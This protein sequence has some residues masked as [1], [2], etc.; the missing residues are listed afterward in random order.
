MK[1]SPSLYYLVSIVFLCLT[2]TACKKTDTVVE[3]YTAIAAEFNTRIDPNNLANYA[4]QGKPAYINKD[5]A[6]GTVITDA[7]ATLGRVL[8]YD[9]QLSVNNTT[10]CGSCHVQKFAFSDTAL[11]SLGVQG[12]RT[13]RHSM[14][15]INT[16][17]SNERRFFWDERAATLE[18]Q[19]TQPI[20]DHAEMGFSGQDGRPTFASLL[21]KLQAIGY[22]QELF[23][24][25]YGDE[26]VTEQRL[27]ECLS[28][29]VR[30]IQSFD[31]K[32]DQG[33]AIAP[34]NQPFPNFTQ[35]ENT[36]K[37]LFQAPP[38]F[39][40]DGVRIAGGLGCAGC[41]A[42]PEFSIDPNSGNNGII[43]VLNGTG[44]DINNTRAPSLRDLVG[45]DGLPN[46]PMMH[47]GGITS[48]NTLIGHYGRIN[49]APGNTRLDPRL[50]PNGLGQNLVLNANEVDAV[51]AFLKT[52]T[53]NAVYTDA[54]WSDPFV[55]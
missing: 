9:K 19:S 1:A 15:L 43:G 25:V 32:Y 45:R 38:Q 37:N 35:Q 22:Y 50:R 5:N 11:S 36:G 42:A 33:R 39:S 49:L 24:F 51:V 54:R 7:K 14:R 6:A 26:N 23:R 53:G 18:E 3:D 41:H 12:G 21:S 20:K 30:S 4:N 28:Q 34:D 29:F 2:Y 55:N 10:S 27:Q 44:I 52:L 16:R 8:F 17:F 48:L 13:G 40:A 46:G 31:S 47:T